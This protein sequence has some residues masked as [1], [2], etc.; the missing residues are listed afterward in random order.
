MSNLL[1][2]EPPLVLSPTLARTVGVGEAIILQQIHYWLDKNKTANINFHDGYYWTF[3]SYEDWQ[4]KSFSF[5]S[6]RTIRRYINSLE[7]RKLLV[8]GNYNKFKR[9]RTKWYRID[10]VALENLEKASDIA[11][12]SD[13]ELDTNETLYIKET[14]VV[15]SQEN[16]C[17]E[18]FKETEVVCS[19]ENI[20][21]EDLG[22]VAVTETIV[23]NE[24]TAKRIFDDNS[25]EMIVVKY[26]IS[27]IKLVGEDIKVPDTDAKLQ[28]WCKVIDYILRIDK[29]DKR[30]LCE[31][32]KVALEDSF[33][34]KNIL[35]PTSLR[36]KFDRLKLLLKDANNKS[37]TN[38]TKSTMEARTKAT[39]DHL[40]TLKGYCDSD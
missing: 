20:C 15:C 3:N 7:E 9:D 2:K 23:K 19:E 34:Q 6:I 4:E 21:K 24:N 36:D 11:L 31:V 33:W 10:Y 14:E 39:L 38:N 40:K 13:C 29:R 22:K 27:K 37:T 18:D 25:D 12:T 28:N 35:S 16:I 8:V 26:L 1:Y 5:W 32:I 17:K 30:E